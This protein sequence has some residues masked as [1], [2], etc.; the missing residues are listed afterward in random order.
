VLLLEHV[1][2][3]GSPEG[4]GP[5]LSEAQP[6]SVGAVTGL[7]GPAPGMEAVAS[8]WRVRERVE[9]EASD[10]FAGLAAGLRARGSRATLVAMAEQA[11]RDEAEHAQLCRCI[12]DACGQ[13]LPPL[14]PARGVRLGP[15]HLT[16]PARVL[17]EAVAISC[18][19]ETLSVALLV[20]MRELIR[21]ERIAATVQRIVR[22]EVQHSRLGWAV[23]AAEAQDTDVAW[24]APHL[25]GMFRD[26]LEGDLLPTAMT[27]AAAEY[28][29][30][31]Y[32]I[33][34][35]RTVIDVVRATAQDV[36]FAGLERFGVDT[37]AARSAWTRS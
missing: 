6:R 35:R 4:R 37:K 14:V 20:T 8:I 5:D 11:A 17:Y 24:L 7:V 33:L 32:G 23:L 28:D 18:V 34:Q 10:L 13:A 29:L 27:D 9:H 16:P 15:R 12:V 2:L 31:A 36:I 25:P 30:S 19:T 22:D 1:L 21:D 26:A 3:V